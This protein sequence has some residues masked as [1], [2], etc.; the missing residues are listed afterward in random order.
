[1]WENIPGCGWLSLRN[2]QSWCAAPPC[3]DCWLCSTVTPE[4][5]HCQMAQGLFFFQE[6][7]L[8][9]KFQ[10]FCSA[11]TSPTWQLS[12]LGSGL[13]SC[14][15]FGCT[16]Q[17][18]VPDFGVQEADVTLW[19]PCRAL[20]ASRATPVPLLPAH[21]KEILKSTLQK[22]EASSIKKRA[23]RLAR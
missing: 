5:G 10:Q 20:P 8:F 7:G 17:G 13:L 9:S 4:G 15:S 11:L 23:H 21:R 18:V 12:R 6:Y 16:G 19:W 1:M 3:A 14:L 22:S 2:E